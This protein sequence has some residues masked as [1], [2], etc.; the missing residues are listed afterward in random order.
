MA[1]PLQAKLGRKKGSDLVGVAICNTEGPAAHAP[2]LARAPAPVWKQYL[3]AQVY[4]H[5]QKPNIVLPALAV[6]GGGR[7]IVA[8]N[9]K[10]SIGY[11]Q[12]LHLDPT[13]RHAYRL[14]ALCVRDHVR[15]AVN[16][17]LVNYGGNHGGNRSYA[18]R[19]Q[20][21]FSILFKLF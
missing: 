21:L 20:A 14:P 3:R 19:P 8:D 13:L 15:Q 6:V 4:R 10:G 18:D 1:P 17:A 12:A 11:R 9:G 2:R 5:I 7:R 16:N